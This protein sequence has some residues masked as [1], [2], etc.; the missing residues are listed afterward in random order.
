MA[1]ADKLKKYVTAIADAIRAKEGSTEKINPQDF[2]Q[3]IENLQVGGGTDGGS[4]RSSWR[5]F[6]V[7]K[8]PMQSQVFG[9]RPTLIKHIGS[10]EIKHIIGTLDN[11][12]LMS[13]IGAFGVDGDGIMFVVQGTIYTWNEAMALEGMTPEAMAQ[14]NVLEITEEEFLNNTFTKE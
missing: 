13:S 8:S 14:M 4:V 10:T 3:R 5:Y 12:G 1:T 9:L 2:V 7:S 6:D 11:D